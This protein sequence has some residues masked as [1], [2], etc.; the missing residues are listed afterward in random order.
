M[1]ITWTPSVVCL[2]SKTRLIDFSATRVDDAN[3]ENVETYVVHSAHVNTV[4]Q[5][6]AIMQNIQIQRDE[7]LAE[8]ARLAA[9]KAVTDALQTQAKIY[10]EENEV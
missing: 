4:E 8:A 5:R 7:A 2:D 6:L 10:L 3:P 9:V 1:A